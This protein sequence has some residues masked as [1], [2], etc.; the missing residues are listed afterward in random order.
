[1]KSVDTDNKDFFLVVDSG[2]KSITEASVK[3]C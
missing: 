3:M 1:M 2:S